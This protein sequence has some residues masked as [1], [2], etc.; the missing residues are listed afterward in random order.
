MTLIKLGQIVW[1]D[2]FTN[3]VPVSKSFFEDVAVWHFV[4]EHGAGMRTISFWHFSMTKRAADFCC[5]RQLD[6][7]RVKICSI[8]ELFGRP[9]TAL[10]ALSMEEVRASRIACEIL[11]ISQHCV[12]RH[13]TGLEAPAI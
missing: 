5:E 7:C 11:V 9:Q 4:I 1:H 8:V 13:R 10:R 12:Q 6:L 2:L 3:N